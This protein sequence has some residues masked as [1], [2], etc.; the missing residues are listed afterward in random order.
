MAQVQAWM[1]SSRFLLNPTKIQYISLVYAARLIARLPK[2]SPVSAYIRDVL[3]WLPISQRISYRTAA[4]VSRCVL[5]CAPSYLRD[6]CR[7]VSDVAAR[8]VLRS[9]TRGELLVPRA[10]LAIKQR[11]AFSV[12]GPSIWNDLPLKLRSL[13]VSH[14]A[15][16]YKSLNLPQVFFL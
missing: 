14:P 7:P 4:V 2:F 13:L 15:G 3:H 10:R 16:F 1:S 5:G 8:R 9:T 6:L 12:V 11:R